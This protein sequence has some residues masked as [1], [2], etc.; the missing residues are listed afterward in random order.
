MGQVTLPQGTANFGL[1]GPSLNAADQMARYPTKQA[2]SHK[3]AQELDAKTRQ[4]NAGFD[5]AR[6]AGPF[7]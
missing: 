5:A 4:E 6:E 1:L 3:A 2:E 7:S